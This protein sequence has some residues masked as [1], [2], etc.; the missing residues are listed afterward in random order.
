LLFNNNG[1]I[2]V[3][4]DAAAGLAQTV[5]MSLRFQG[6]GK[7]TNSS[8]SGAM[9]SVGDIGFTTS[10]ATNLLVSGTG[11]INVTGVISDANAGGIAGLT[12]TGAGTLTLA[13][14][15]T[16]TGSTTIAGGVVGVSNFAALGQSPDAAGNLFLDGGTLRFTGQSGGFTNRSFTLGPGGGTLDAS[17]TAIMS[18]GSTS[19]IAFSTSNGPTALMLTGTGNGGLSPAIGNNGTG[20]T[21]LTKTGAGTWSL[22]GTNSF[23]GAVTVQ[24]GTLWLATATAGGNNA[25]YAVS[26][27]TTLAVGSGKSDTVAIGSLAGAG[28]VSA[29][30]AGGA[31]QTNTLTAGGDG[32]STG[33]AGSLQDS[34]HIL[35][36]NKIGPGTLTLS[37]TNNSYSGPTTVTAGTLR[38]N[39]IITASAVTVSGTGIV[40]G[41]GTVGN[42]LRV[43]SGGK[44][45]PGTSI[46]AL[47]GST[48]TFDELGSFDWEIAFA[49]GDAG[50]GYDLLKLSGGL[51]ITAT[52]GRKFTINVLSL[53]AVK[54]FNPTRGYLWTLV[55]TAMG[56]KG[57]DPDAFAINTESF[58]PGSGTF[59]VETFSGDLVLK[60]TPIPEPNTALLIGAGMVVAG[61]ARRKR[62][63][64]KR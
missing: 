10:T 21:S 23:S 25:A 44:V 20:A 61:C 49:D 58:F 12:K 59:G 31:G 53:G 40:D 36:L 51:D 34:S 60:F 56:I 54:D 2:N 7:L 27:A 16:Y 5:S 14:A 15:N 6:F 19:G 57:F 26:P 64:V 37:H 33:F 30:L 9:L 42:G 39:G 45:S 55:D 38:V 22:T 1:E 52:A 35:A 63:P 47:T 3:A 43:T 13:S 62:S 28:T 11:A 4:F 32:T 17:G 18:F 48:A 41:T 8:Q 50:D 29:S 24:Q 46:G